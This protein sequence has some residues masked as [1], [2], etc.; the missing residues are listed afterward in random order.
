MTFLKFIYI[1]NAIPL[2]SFPSANPLSNPLPLLLWGC[3]PTHPLPLHCLSISL[4]W[5]IDPSQDQ[6][7]LLPL[8]LDKAILCYI[9]EEPWV[10]PCVLFGWWFTPW[11]L[12]VVWLV[13]IVIPMGFQ[14]LPAPPVFPLTPPLGFHWSVQWLAASICIYIGQALA[15]P[16]R[17]QIYIRLLSASTTWHQ[18]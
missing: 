7:P 12:W 5:S 17:R 10:P 18:Q 8:M 14:T 3:S 1:S 16:L 13:D 11:E 6:G 9:F 2:P 4:H 15:E